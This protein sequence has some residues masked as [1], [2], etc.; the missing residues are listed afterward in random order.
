LAAWKEQYWDLGAATVSEVLLFSPLTFAGT[1]LTGF[2]AF[3]AVLGV[4]VGFDS[5]GTTSSFTLETRRLDLRGSS[6]GI[7]SSKSFA[8]RLA[9]V[10]DIIERA[11]MITSYEYDDR[12][13]ILSLDPA[14]GIKM[15]Q[16][17]VTR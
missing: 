12:R 14:A 6:A 7:P 15:N 17:H 1:S 5:L 4:D 11:L 9:I 13:H 8:L 2:C 3:L 16:S 10:W